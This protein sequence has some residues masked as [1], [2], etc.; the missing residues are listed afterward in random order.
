MIWQEH[1]LSRSVH[2]ILVDIGRDNGAEHCDVLSL[3]KYCDSAVSCCRF[4]FHIAGFIAHC[5]IVVPTVTIAE[6]HPGADALDVFIRYV[7]RFMKYWP[8]P[9]L[10]GLTCLRL[11]VSLNC[12]NGRR[13]SK[14]LC[15]SLTATCTSDWET[16][17]LLI[18]LACA[19]YD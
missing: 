15:W 14:T 19:S 6:R 4:S 18:R 8:F 11:R 2:C 3:C 10:C 5:T 1:S 9:R 13:R 12:R 16:S 17:Q 7:R